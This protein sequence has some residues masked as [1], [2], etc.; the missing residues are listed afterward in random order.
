MSKVTKWMLSYKEENQ[1]DIKVFEV[2]KMMPIN[3]MI[4]QLDPVSV[5]LIRVQENSYLCTYDLND[6]TK[7][8]VSKINPKNH[9]EGFINLSEKDRPHMDVIAKRFL[10]KKK[11]FVQ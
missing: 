11:S 7:V 6:A 10:K 2:P 5:D 9:Q 1:L 4:G 3:C 8:L